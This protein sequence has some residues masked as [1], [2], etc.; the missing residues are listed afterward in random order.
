M[1]SCAMLAGTSCALAPPRKL[2]WTRLKGRNASGQALFF[3]YLFY[4]IFLY[5]FHFWLSY[6]FSFILF[7]SQPPALQKSWLTAACNHVDVDALSHLPCRVFQNTFVVRCTHFQQSHGRTQK[8]PPVRVLATFFFVV[9][10]FSHQLVF[11][12]GQYEP[13][14]RSN[15]T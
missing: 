10:V 15:W 2:D 14:S 9:V 6:R 5:F 7:K 12:R 3:C 13:L 4:Q 8:I 11:H 1:I